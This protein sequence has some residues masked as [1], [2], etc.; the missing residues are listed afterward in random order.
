M[1]GETC[2]D[3]PLGSLGEAVKMVILSHCHTVALSL[4]VPLNILNFPELQIF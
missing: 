2:V 4:F 3:V 1:L